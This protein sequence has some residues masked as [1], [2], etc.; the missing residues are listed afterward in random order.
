MRR[1]ID[2]RTLIGKGK[3][4]ELAA[5]EDPEEHYE[6]NHENRRT[7]EFG[8]RESPSNEHGQDDPELSH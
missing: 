8:Q 7:N 6:D 2:P 1:Q 3:L 4:E 5:K